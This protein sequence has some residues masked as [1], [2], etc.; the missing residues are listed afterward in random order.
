MLMLPSQPSFDS[1][2]FSL[3]DSCY[4]YFYW[5]N[6]YITLNLV[7]FLNQ[8]YCNFQW[9]PGILVTTRAANIFFSLKDIFNFLLRHHLGRTKKNFGRTSPTKV[10][11]YILKITEKTLLPIVSQCCFVTLRSSLHKLRFTQGRFLIFLNIKW[12]TIK[13]FSWH[14]VRTQV[15]FCRTLVLKYAKTATILN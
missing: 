7:F 4:F 11:L 13:K 8:S 14:N 12:F 2:V 15:G 10:E 3:K 9:N 5:L 1:H 6:Y